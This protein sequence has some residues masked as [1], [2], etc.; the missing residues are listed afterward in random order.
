MEE[1]YYFV[2]VNPDKW[3]SSGDREECIEGRD[4]NYL[5]MSGNGVDCFV[6][7]P[8]E[9][10]GLFSGVKQYVSW[11]RISCDEGGEEKVPIE[12]RHWFFKFRERWAEGMRIK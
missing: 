5:G 10:E 11:G 9:F 12:L 2:F 8:G 1:K 4:M 7:R 3:E 6:C